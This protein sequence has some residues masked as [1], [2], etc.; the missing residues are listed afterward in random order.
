L[1]LRSVAVLT[2]DHSLPRADW[3]CSSSAIMP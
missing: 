3:R 1:P 2:D